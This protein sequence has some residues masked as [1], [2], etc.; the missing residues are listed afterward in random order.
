MAAAFAAPE[1]HAAAGKSITG[2]KTTIVLSSPSHHALK[3]H[4]FTL[5]ANGPARYKAGTLTLPVTGGTYDGPLD[6]VVKQGGGF[7]ISKGSKSVSI[8][9]LVDH[10][11]SLSATARVSGHGRIAA[12]TIGIPGSSNA[13]DTTATFADYQ[14][15]LS[16]QLV[17]VLDT[18]FGTRQ[19]ARHATIGTGTTKLTFS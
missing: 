3:A 11:N 5:E 17:K 19:F 7:T 15:T 18:T 10:T 13:T 1:G 6:S 9:K 2:K 8:N 14:V 16:K 12:V 4:H